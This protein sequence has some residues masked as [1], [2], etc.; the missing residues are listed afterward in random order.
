MD[1][2]A[3]L[4]KPGLTS[5]RGRGILLLCGVGVMP[6]VKGSVHPPGSSLFPGG[7]VGVKARAEQATDGCK[8][9]VLSPQDVPQVLG[10]DRQLPPLHP[11]HE[12]WC[13]RSP[14]LMRI[15][16]KPIRVISG[17][18]TQV[19]A[20]CIYFV[21]LFKPNCPSLPSY[22]AGVMGASSRGPAETQW[23]TSQRKQERSWAR[24]SRRFGLRGGSARVAEGRT[25]I[26]AFRP[27]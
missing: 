19:G 21:L 10:Q 24:K 23:K 2:R 9:G 17:S 27:G 18:R 14:R 7:T 15:E 22:V 11:L 20:C 16:S 4:H 3:Y 8:G 1:E 5:A 13:R 26:P 6:Q 12:H 25:R